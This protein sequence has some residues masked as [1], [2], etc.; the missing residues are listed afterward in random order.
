MSAFAELAL[1][2]IAWNP[3][4][5]ATSSLGAI[6]VPVIAVALIAL[7]IIRRRRR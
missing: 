2:D 3:V 5:E 4:A 7:V 1:S 6:A